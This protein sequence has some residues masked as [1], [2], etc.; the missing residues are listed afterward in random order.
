MTQV[1]LV[2]LYFQA[3]ITGI[4]I[5]YFLCGYRSKKTD[6]VAA[7]FDPKQNVDNLGK[8]TAPKLQGLSPLPQPTTTPKSVISKFPD[9]EK[10]R[11]QKDQD[12]VA[13][14]LDDMQKNKRPAGAFVI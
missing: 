10:V 5:G 14:Y 7:N 2:L 9:P 6:P 11:Q 12:Q 8:V 13:A 4:C 3:I 1:L